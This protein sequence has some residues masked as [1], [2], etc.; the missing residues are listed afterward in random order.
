MT[1]WLAWLLEEL[2][3]D[4]EQGEDLDLSGYILPCVLEERSGDGPWTEAYSG[5]PTDLRAE[6]A[7][8]ET[9]RARKGSGE[10]QSEEKDEP[11][12]PEDLPQRLIRLSRARLE[13]EAHQL[14]SKGPELAGALAGT[15]VVR[16]SEGGGK[17]GQQTADA[18]RK[19]RERA[20]TAAALYDSV[21]RAGMA[22]EQVPYLRQPGQ[23]V[24]RELEP[25]GG[26][27]PTPAE[28]D[29]IFQRDARRYDGGF[30]L[31]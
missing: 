9:A 15:G 11:G 16:L 20:L 22:A 17:P 29:R 19:E 25:V 14:G 6:G 23:V 2:E 13:Q 18:G 31:F 8:G 7:S 3:E 30:T 26:Q 27:G 21:R 1:D 10:D 24:V 4:G 5:G 12:G 28:L